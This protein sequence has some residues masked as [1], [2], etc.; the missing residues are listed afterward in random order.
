MESLTYVNTSAYM[1]C[2]R[3]Y[4]RKNNSIISAYDN[5]GSISYPAAFNNAIGVSWNRLIRSVKQYYYIENSPVEILD[6][7]G[8]KD[9]LGRRK[10]INM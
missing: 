2:A 9:C 3:V 1:I 10:N 5:E 4:A 6:M 8:N 7:Q